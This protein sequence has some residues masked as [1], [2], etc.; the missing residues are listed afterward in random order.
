MAVWSSNARQRGT[1][2]LL[3]QEIVSHGAPFSSVHTLRFRQAPLLFA[4]IFF[5]AGTTLQH[6][7]RPAALLAVA[8][9]LLSGCGLLALWRAPRLILPTLGIVWLVLGWACATMRPALQP[10]TNVLGYADGLHRQLIGTVVAVSGPRPVIARDRDPLHWDET[11]LDTVD[12]DPAIPEAGSVDLKLD[13]IEQVTPDVSTMVPLEGGVRLVLHQR[14]GAAPFP[15]LH[16]GDQVNLT[17]RL[18]P[19]S[20]YRD[21]GVWQ[22]PEYL[23]AD[24][25]SATGTATSAILTGRNSAPM[26]CRWENMRHRASDRLD[27]FAHWQRHLHLP[28]ALR[29]TPTDAGLLNAMLFGDRTDLQHSLRVQ[30]ERT[31]SFHL[32]VVAGMH[33]GFVAAGVYWLLTRL[34]IRRSIAI[35]LSFSLTAG[36]ALLTGFGDPVQRALW[37]TGAYLLAQLLG[38]DRN[39]LNA[40]G[41]ASLMLLAA[42]PQ[43]LF[44][45]AFQ[46]TVLVI[47]AI[48]GLAMPLLQRTWQPYLHAC[49]H[50][51]QQRLDQHVPPRIAQFRVSLRFAAG[52]LGS[53]AGSWARR[54]PT[55][56]TWTLLAALELS[57]LSL[58]AE[59]VMALPMAFYFHRITPFALPANLLVVPILPL[60]LASAILTFL[61]SLLTPW[62]ALLPALLTAALLRWTAL[63]V[64]GFSHLRIADVRIGD[65]PHWAAAT[66]VFL[67]CVAL[68]GVRQRPRTLGWLAVAMVPL[69]MLITVLPYPAHLYA[70]ALEVTAIDVGQGDALLLAAPN[71]STML[72]DAGGQVG[73]EHS[74]RAPTFDTGESV[75]SP[76][77]WSRGLRHL[78]VLVV[79]H[80]HMDHIGGMLAILDN[81]RPH[82]LWLSVDANSQTLH[83][84]VAEADALHVTVR[85]LH[86]G[87]RPTWP[88]GIVSVLNP[89]AGRQGGEEP[90]ND[91]SVV[92]RTSFGAAS[93]LLDGDAEH[94]SEDRMAAEGLLQP[95]TLLKVG[96]HGS[97]TSTSQAFLDAVRPQAAVISCG[98]GNR[99]G[100]PRLAVLERLQAGHV[101]TTRTDTMG[102]TQYLLHANGTY[103]VHFPG[104]GNTWQEQP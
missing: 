80:A 2:S 85:H 96:H 86:R 45:S 71:G 65:P 39:A 99:F 28:L 103:E 12:D 1:P 54:L 66:A 84:L 11:R 8:S 77:L 4:A 94:P 9:V 50:L 27:H 24:G 42:R 16:C 62:L 14:A 49:R 15:E 55:W 61:A 35:L 36:Y 37:M 76:Y 20:R 47:L 22:Y 13:R 92:L 40:L 73:S 43:T 87:D 78:D 74:A 25:I 48:G 59:M 30:F 18:R 64:G 26:A 58:L 7:W 72:I 70:D 57:I 41:L 34:R 33:V 100:H 46:M 91:D 32:F 5:A 98:R 10:S 52:L 51:D 102:A 88:G 17:A 101:Q 53:A 83:T 63:V 6:F 81:F 44:D 95:V 82:E 97:L 68:F 79:T 29:W 104:L 67:L 60:L 23:A 3:G 31:G 89:E 93:V 21:P 19:P 69:F 38:R 90:G 75:V 56:T